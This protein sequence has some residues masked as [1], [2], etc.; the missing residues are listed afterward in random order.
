VISFL[1]GELAD[2]GAGRVVV[3]V[4][5]VGYD[6]QVPAST[7]ARL[8]GVGDARDCSPGCTCAMMA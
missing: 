8:P 2:K 4:H 6:V 1:E 7:I 5:G 3:A